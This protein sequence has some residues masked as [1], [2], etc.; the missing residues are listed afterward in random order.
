[1]AEL[2]TRRFGPYT[3]ETSNE[4]KV[5]FRDSGITKGELIDYYVGIAEH[6]LPQIHDRP[7]S[8]QRFPDGIGEEG[9]YQK[10]L[11]GYFPDWID[12]VEVDTHDGRQRQGVCSNRATLAYLAQQACVTPHV[13]LSRR[14]RLDC[15]DRFVIDL[16][17]PGD[18][19]PPV[20]R[21]ALAVRD[22]LAELELPAWCMTTGSRGLHVVVPLDRSQDFDAA[23][24]FGRRFARALAAREDK[25]LTFE[26]RK[27]KR[28][29]RV[30][31]DTSNLAYGQ[32]AVCPYAVRARPGA[33]VATPITWDELESGDVGPRSWTLLTL[34]EHLEGGADPFGDLARHGRSLARAAEA[35]GK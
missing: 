6:I 10:E 7:L 2:A 35:L 14:D 17:P 11:P 32:T 30:Y 3:V 25:T 20:R 9:F 1:V 16:D 27:A 19:F 31:L 4:D 33:P 5:L 34:P 28:G 22:F 24:D 29:R 13:W 15:P 23:R 21:A 18:D 12:S 8:M 26:Q